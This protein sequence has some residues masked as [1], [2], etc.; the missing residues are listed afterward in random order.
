[1]KSIQE[2]LHSNL[3]LPHLGGLFVSMAKKKKKKTT[4]QEIFMSLFFIQNYTFKKHF[5]QK[6]QFNPSN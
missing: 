3:L 5:M 4:M 1:M 6:Y 2:F